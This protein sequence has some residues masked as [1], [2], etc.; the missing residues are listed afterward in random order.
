MIAAATYPVVQLGESEP[1]LMFPET[2]VPLVS[3]SLFLY[4][5]FLP[6]DDKRLSLGII[7]V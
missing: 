7:R 3:C 2:D 4:G 1:R 6:I 5:I